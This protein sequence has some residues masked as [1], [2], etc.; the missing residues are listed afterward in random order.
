MAASIPGVQ[1]D[2]AYDQ[3]QNIF[4]AEAPPIQDD[5]MQEVSGVQDDGDEDAMDEDALDDNGEPIQK[6]GKPRKLR[7]FE[8]TGPQASVAQIRDLRLLTQFVKDFELNIKQ[9][10]IDE[11]LGFKERTSRRLRKQKTKSELVA[12]GKLERHPRADN[13]KK[14]L[15]VKAAKRADKKKAAEVETQLPL[16]DQD[17]IQQEPP[18]DPAL[19]DGYME[20]WQN[21]LQGQFD[22]TNYH[23]PQQT[24]Q[25][26]Q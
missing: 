14:A 26:L 1:S 21:Q 5:D 24:L 20:G 16:Q 6:S 17:Q 9:R 8:K 12:E 13:A 18:V 23:Q 7:I 4:D 15:K 10:E 22:P 11:Y 2:R 3:N 19:P 25:G